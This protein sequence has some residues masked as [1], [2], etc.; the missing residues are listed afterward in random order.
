VGSGCVTD[1]SCSG[2]TPYCDS[3]GVCVACLTNAECSQGETCQAGACT[4]VA[5]TCASNADCAGNT[6]A[7]F[8]ST[9]FGMCV[10]CI[11][12]TAC[13]LGDICELGTCTYEGSQ[14]TCQSDNDCVGSATDPLCDPT[15]GKC[16]PCIGTS[17]TASCGAGTVTGTCQ[18]DVCVYGCMQLVAC[19]NNCTTESC[20]ASCIAE[21]STLGQQLFEALDECIFSSQNCPDTSGGICDGSAPGYDA[22]L[23]SECITEAQLGPCAYNLQVCDSD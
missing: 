23:C 22:S 9:A 17:D 13:D 7:P 10:R 20:E 5:T 2:S 12:Y 6:A 19:L 8:C 18:N 14:T 16:V 11:D 21:T 3:G 1:A 4:S 15:L